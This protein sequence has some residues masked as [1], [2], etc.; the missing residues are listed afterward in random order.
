[1]WLVERTVKFDLERPNDI[2]Y[3]FI[4]KLTINGRM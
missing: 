2:R 3:I 4:Q 1:M